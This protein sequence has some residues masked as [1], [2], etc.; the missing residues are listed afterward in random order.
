MPSGTRRRRSRD[1][2]SRKARVAGPQAW[3]QHPC[4]R[5]PNLRLAVA[6]AAGPVGRRPRAP[7][8][9][10]RPSFARYGAAD[11]LFTQAR[12]GAVRLQVRGVDHQRLGRAGLGRTRGEDMRD[13]ARPA[14][15]DPAV[16][17]ALG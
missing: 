4:R 14:P 8:S 2:R 10:G 7:L 16:V 9:S 6:R 11:L 15:A 13:D 3:S 12:S 17:K 5:W 1:R